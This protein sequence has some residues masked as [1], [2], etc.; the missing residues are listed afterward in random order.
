MEEL[1]VGVVAEFIDDGG[2]EIDKDNARDVLAEF[3]FIEEGVVGHTEGDVQAKIAL[4][5][6]RNYQYHANIKVW[7]SGHGRKQ[8]EELDITTILIKLMLCILFQ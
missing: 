3:D 4:V 1:T 2:F 6:S 7:I 5:C 8:E